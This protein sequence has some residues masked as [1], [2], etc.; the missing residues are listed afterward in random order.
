VSPDATTYDAVANLIDD[1]PTLV[2]DN[3]HHL[4]LTLYDAAAEIGVSPATL[5]RLENRR[6]LGHAGVI[7]ACLRW[8]HTRAPEQT[9]PNG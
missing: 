4:G 9:V 5:S 7:T 1:I 8:L 3:R 2:R 6:R